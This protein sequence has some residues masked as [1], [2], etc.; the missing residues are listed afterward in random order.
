[1]PSSR[2]CAGL[3]M[4]V[5]D[6]VVCVFGIFFVPARVALMRELW[7]LGAPG[8]HLV[9]WWSAARCQ[10]LGA[11]ADPT[12]PVNATLLAYRLTVR[13]DGHGIFTEQGQSTAF[14]S[15]PLNLDT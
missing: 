2:R 6:A 12:A 13:P 3:P 7:R 9:R 5:V 15:C 8:A 1:M 14:G 11:F 4:E 10:Q